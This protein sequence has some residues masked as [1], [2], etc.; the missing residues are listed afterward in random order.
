MRACVY[1]NPDFVKKF[2]E[3]HPCTHDIATKK[4]LWMM[5]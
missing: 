1:Y 4:Y 5:V 2:I 3:T